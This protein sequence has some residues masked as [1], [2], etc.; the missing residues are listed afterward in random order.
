MAHTNGAAGYLRLRP[1]VASW[2]RLP[3]SRLGVRGRPAARLVTSAG[4]TEPALQQREIVNV[5]L[6]A[7]RL[8]VPSL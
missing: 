6:D 8:P 1:G 2:R 7:G 3:R 4:D 5:L